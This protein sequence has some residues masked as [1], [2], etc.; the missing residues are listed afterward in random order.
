MRRRATWLRASQAAA[1]A[2]AT[3]LRRERESP[4][5]VVQEAGIRLS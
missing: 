4:V 2:F 1:L 5:L 3:Y